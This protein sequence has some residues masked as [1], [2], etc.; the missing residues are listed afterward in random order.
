MSGKRSLSQDSWD[1]TAR[2]IKTED[3]SATVFRADLNATYRSTAGA[4]GESRYVFFDGSGLSTKQDTWHVLELGFGMGTNFRTVQQ[5]AAEAGIF[6][7][8]HAVEYQPVP[9]SVFSGKDFQDELLAQVFHKVRQSH[10][11]VSI[12]SP[13]WSLSLYISDWRDLRWEPLGVDAVFHDPFGPDTNPESWGVE[14]FQWAHRHLHRNGALVT[15]GAAGHVRRAMR[16]AGLFVASA[17][18]FGPKREMTVAARS[19]DRLQGHDIRFRPTL[20]EK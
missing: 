12:E 8:Y 10:H 11:P 14:V 2:V 19:E 20:C 7:K 17:K 1:D 3:G 18:G 4:A 9:A 13:Q 16:D 15:Y 6:L 5:A